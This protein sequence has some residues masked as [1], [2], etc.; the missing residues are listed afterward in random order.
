MLAGLRRFLMSPAIGPISMAVAVALAALLGVSA[1]LWRAERAG[2]EA[3]IAELSRAAERT[4]MSL[5]AELT[6]CHQA[7]AARLAMEAELAKRGPAPERARADA[8]LA[9]QPEGIDACARMESADRAVLS[10]LKR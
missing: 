4:Q 8:L 1:S 10:N 6:A 9:A 5:R 2:Y 7:D 3:R